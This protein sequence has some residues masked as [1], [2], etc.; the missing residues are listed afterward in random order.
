MKKYL[1]L[2][3]LLLGGCSFDEYSEVDIFDSPSGL[4]INEKEYRLVLD[5]GHV[6][7]FDE[8]CLYPSVIGDHK[9]SYDSNYLYTKSDGGEFY[10]HHYRMVKGAC[11]TVL[12]PAIL[13]NANIK[14]YFESML[15][16][17]GYLYTSLDE[18]S[19]YI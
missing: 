10:T 13:H 7:Y 19:K 1:M 12:I 17:R 5:V 9:F 8:D 15:Y 18:K 16:I 2:V 4:T 6:V 11:S 3:G 14:P